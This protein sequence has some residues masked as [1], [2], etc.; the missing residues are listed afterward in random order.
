MTAIRSAL[1]IEPKCSSHSTSYAQVDPTPID[2]AMSGAGFP[3]VIT[4]QPWELD[5]ELITS[6]PVPSESIVNAKD[7]GLT[8]DEAGHKS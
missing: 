3:V 5:V 1:G 7:F 6:H 2:E 4:I 8:V